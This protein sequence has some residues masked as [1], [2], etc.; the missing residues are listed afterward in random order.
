MEKKEAIFPDG[1]IFKGPRQGAPE[2]IKAA[3]S[4][5]VSQFIPFLE[6]HSKNGWV[7]LDV[8]KSQKGSLYVQLDDWKSSK[9]TEE[10]EEL[11]K[12]DAGQKDTVNVPK[13]A[14]E[15]NPEDIPF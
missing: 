15:I 7:N 9:D 2:F 4:I 5:K 11:A 12:H 3:I 1:F 13:G 6:K 10:Q 8:K 14:D